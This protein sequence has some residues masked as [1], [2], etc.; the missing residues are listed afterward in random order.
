MKADQDSGSGIQVPL[1]RPI[2]TGSATILGAAGRLLLLLCLSLRGSLVLAGDPPQIT[3]PPAPFDFAMLEGRTFQFFVKA[4]GTPPLQYQ[5]QF[6]GENIRGAT[7][8]VLGFTLFQSRYAGDYRV[9]V[10]NAYGTVQS[11]LVHLT[12]D[13]GDLPMTDGFDERQRSDAPFSN[14]LPANRGTGRSSNLKATVERGKGEPNHAGVYGGA[15]MWAT[16]T[17]S[18]SGVATFSTVGSAIDTVLAVYTAK[19]PAAPVVGG[20]R[21]VTANDN[22]G[23]GVKGSE[24]GRAH[25]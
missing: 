2:G 8:P 16:W 6:N 3:Q 22:A 24:I 11:D 12:V 9:I 1:G 10:R 21:E 7:N 14:R 18:A 15:S 23:D 20:L 5:W 19:D 17:P 13:V 4:T 25:V